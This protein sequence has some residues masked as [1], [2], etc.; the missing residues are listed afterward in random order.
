[1]RFLFIFF[2]T[3][4]S[5]ASEMEIHSNHFEYNQTSN[6]SK[7]IGDVNITKE[8]DNILSDTLFIYMDK[9]KT[10]DK[11]IAIGNVKF[12]INEKNSTYKGRSDKVIY[13]VPTQIV[14]FEGKVKILR[15][16]ENQKLYGDKVIINKK[17]GTAEVLGE[18]NK[19]IKFVIKVK[20]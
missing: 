7:F 11:L 4:F 16:P 12:I 14:I 5:F 1:M 18:K 9:N 10:L 20:E 19:P 17:E 13:I 6:I 8:K 3:I 2:I 15:L